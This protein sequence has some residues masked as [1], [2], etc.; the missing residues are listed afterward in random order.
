[1][2]NKWATYLGVAL[3]LGVFEGL[4][5]EFGT[6]VGCLLFCF[7][8]VNEISFQMSVETIGGIFITKSMKIVQNRT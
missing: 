8:N 3:L 6:V 5:C 2:T 1:M 7:M 4:V